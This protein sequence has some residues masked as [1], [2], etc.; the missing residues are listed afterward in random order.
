MVT[1]IN[2]FTGIYAYC[3]V[4][5]M[6]NLTEARQALSKLLSDLEVYEFGMHNLQIEIDTTKADIAELK[7]EVA[8]LEAEE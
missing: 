8:L 6:I 4:L 2:C 5:N 3:E 7:E 1:T